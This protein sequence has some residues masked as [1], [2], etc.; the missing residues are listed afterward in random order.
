M[1]GAE[2]RRRGTHSSEGGGSH[3][4]SFAIGVAECCSELGRGDGGGA[5]HAA[6]R[7]GGL[8]PHL[9]FGIGKHGG[10]LP[11]EERL[12]GLHPTDRSRGSGAHVV[13]GDFEE[14]LDP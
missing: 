10:K 5:T 6:Q 4:A 8:A 3:A 9:D 11:G 7:G 2:I 13:M 1:A 14:S 12:D